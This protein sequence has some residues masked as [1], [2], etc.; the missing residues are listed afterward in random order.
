MYQSSQRF[1]PASSRPG[2][3]AMKSFMDH[4][5]TAPSAASANAMPMIG[6]CQ[7]AMPATSIMDEEPATPTANVP[8]PLN[9]ASTCEAYTSGGNLPVT[10]RPF[11]L[12][13]NG[14]ASRYP[15]D[16][17]RRDLCHL[18]HGTV[19]LSFMPPVPFGLRHSQKRV[20]F[21]R[22]CRGSVNRR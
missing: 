6:R 14:M 7:P 22:F 1:S 15:L 21:G 17:R 19:E 8:V 5:R 4:N 16:R 20:V 3:T 9:R 11:V 12:V 10:G 13:P 2:R 18:S